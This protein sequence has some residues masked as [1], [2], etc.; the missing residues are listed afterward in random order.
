MRGFWPPG[1]PR[2]S[3]VWWKC[4]GQFRRTRTSLCCLK[5]LLDQREYLETCRIG[6]QHVA[7][8]HFS[9]CRERPLRNIRSND[10]LHLIY[11][12]G[13]KRSF[14]VRVPKFPVIVMAYVVTYTPE[15]N[16]IHIKPL[17]IQYVCKTY[18]R[19]RT[20][21]DLLMWYRQEQWGAVWLLDIRECFCNNVSWRDLAVSIEGTWGSMGLAQ[22]AELQVNKTHGF[23]WKQGIP[24]T[25][26]VHRQFAQ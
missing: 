10:G 3:S 4:A 5:Q 7:M 26:V 1:W 11:L 6:A 15:N 24:K 18:T 2:A 23:V 21:D 25:P 22:N 17:C 8:N 16:Q 12:A 13:P 20:T 19:T 9:I 14:A